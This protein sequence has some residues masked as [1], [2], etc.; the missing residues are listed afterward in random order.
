M[1]SRFSKTIN[2][3]TER[4]RQ[5]VAASTW[6]PPPRGWM[7]LNTDGAVATLDGRGSIGGVLC[8]STS[9]WITGFTK[10]IGTTSVLH[11]ELW[12]IY[13]GMGSGLQ[14]RW[15]T[16]PLIKVENPQGWSWQDLFDDMTR[17]ASS[18]AAST[19]ML[20][21]STPA[22]S[23]ASGRISVEHMEIIE[24]GSTV[25]DDKKDTAKQD[26]EA[27]NIEKPMISSRNASKSYMN[28]VDS[29]YLGSSEKVSKLMARATLFCPSFLQKTYGKER[30]DIEHLTVDMG[31]RR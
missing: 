6:S 2:S 22:G 7:C 3:I 30:T 17:L 15:K 10:N 18:V 25:H 1:L 24:E 8:N 11:A 4:P 16:L 26:I 19:A 31:K 13:E 21:A 29:S 9:D 5:H 12:S 23:R 14:I 20:A 28:L 27:Q